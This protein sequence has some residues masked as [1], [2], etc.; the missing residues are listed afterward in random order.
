MAVNVLKQV[1][2]TRKVKKNAYFDIKKIQR[3]KF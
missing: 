1:P 3:A 2:N